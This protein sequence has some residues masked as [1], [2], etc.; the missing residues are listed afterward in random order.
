MP[1]PGVQSGNI[2]GLNPSAGKD[3]NFKD[4]IEEHSFQHAQSKLYFVCER[5][6]V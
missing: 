5:F 1:K 4:F 6:N 2:V 3:I